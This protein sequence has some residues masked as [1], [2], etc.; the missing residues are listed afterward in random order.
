MGVPSNHWL[1]VWIIF[2]FP[3]YWEYNWLIF[4][5]GVENTNQIIYIFISILVRFSIMNH[6][7]LGCTYPHLRKPPNIPE[8]CT[9][10]L[11]DP[12]FGTSAPPHDFLHALVWKP[13]VWDMILRIRGQRSLS[14]ICIYSFG[15]NSCFDFFWYFFNVLWAAL[16]KQSSLQLW[17]FHSILSAESRCSARPDFADSPPRP[18]HISIL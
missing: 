17:S 4:F 10:D 16:L 12:D 11:F 18:S 3:I 14:G 9:H 2:Y 15:I 13:S 7:I 5:R 6:P 8:W 1:V